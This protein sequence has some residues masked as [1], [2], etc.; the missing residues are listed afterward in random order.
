MKTR[1][2]I[3][4]NNC[5]RH[6]L[7]AIF[8]IAPDFSSTK[9]APE[10][11]KIIL[12]QT[13]K[14][15]EKYINEGVSSYAGRLQKYSDF[16]IISLPEIRNTKNMPVNE[17]KEKEGDQIMG[18]LKKDDYAVALDEKGREFTTLELSGKTEKILMLS[19]KRLV[20]IVGGPFGIS[21]KVLAR[22][23]L[24]LSLSRLTFSHQVVRL[25]FMEQL[26]RVFT[27]IRGEPYHHE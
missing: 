1:A 11:M 13:G 25:L 24:I 16:E 7:I 8:A 2:A 3:S 23:D 14:T 27:V 21:E 17:Q 15:S 26:Y 10:I 4:I 6:I 19:K 12:L 9:V 18:Y 5:C 22:A 20:F